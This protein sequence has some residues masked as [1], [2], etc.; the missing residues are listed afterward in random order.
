LISNKLTVLPDMFLSDNPAL[1]EV[2]VFILWTKGF[3]FL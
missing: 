2:L 3:F 1:E